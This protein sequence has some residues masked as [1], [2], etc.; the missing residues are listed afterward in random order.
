MTN[1]T[2]DSSVKF[3]LWIDDDRLL[4]GHSVVS[5]DEVG[6]NCV[7]C[8]N[9]DRALEIIQRESDRIS[10]MIVDVMMRPAE[11]LQS[12]NTKKGFES[13]LRFLDY[14]ATNDLGGH[15]PKILYTNSKLSGEYQVKILGREYD[16]P[17]IEKI[18]IVKKG[19]YLADDF[20]DYVKS[21]VPVIC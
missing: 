20:A 8:D 4:L 7:I 10:L 14:L 19:K 6:V 5:L 16:D 2:S 17:N 21:L 3:V 9:F 13:G 18:K 1:T 15:I 11:F 12:Y